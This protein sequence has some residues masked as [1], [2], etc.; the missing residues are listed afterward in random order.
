M[1]DWSDRISKLS[2]K[3][4][5]FLALE[6]QEK[7]EALQRA[8]N[9]P[10]AIVGAGCR[11]PGGADGLDSFWQLLDAG[12]DAVTQVPGDR[13]NADAF[14]DPNPDAGGKTYTKH[15]AFVKNLDLFEPQFFGISP[16]E[17]VSLDPQQR[18]LLEVSWEALEAAGQVPEKLLA[19]RTGVFVGI[20]SGDYMRL[21]T[22]S[23]APLDIYAGTGN[24]PSVA[25]G[26]L[27]YTLGLQGPCVA[28]DT[29][30]SS[31]LIAVHLACQSLRTGECALALAGGV[32]A[33]LTPDT[34][35]M[36][37]RGRMIAPDGHCKT[38]DAAADGY[39]RGEGCGVVVLKRLSDALSA[40]DRILAVL[41]GSAINQDGRSSGL[42]APNGPAQEA[43]IR[44]ALARAAVE[45]A[46]V[47]YVE[48]HGTG[49]P[50]GDPIEVQAL[51]SV[52]GAGRSAADP[53]LIGS[54]KTNIGHLEAAAGVA[55]LIK[56]VLALQHERI[57][58]HINF[59]EP[60]PFIP[61]ASLPVKVTSQAV[62]W[63]RGSRRRIA[64]IS[65]FGFSGSNAHVIVEEAPAAAPA[66]APDVE[67]PQ[68]LLTLSARTQ[69]ALTATAHAYA[70][71]L[72][73]GGAAALAD[74]CFS[75]NTGRS[76]FERRLAVSGPSAEAIASALESFAAGSTPSR[77]VS[78]RVDPGV[79]ADV[80]FLFTGQGSQ[81]RDMA[82]E[83]YDTQ[84]VFRAALDR[85][86]AAL[87]GELPAPLLDVLYPTSSALG[88]SA[89]SA[90]FAS[91]I[92]ETRFTQPALFAVEWA[93]SELWR[94][95][96]VRPAV[97][98][99]HSIGE[100]VAACV[101]GVFS[102][103]DALKL[104]AA[105]GR[106]MQAMPAG[107]AMAAV[108][109]EEARARDA[110]APYASTVSIAAINAPRQVVLS[111]ARTELASAVRQLEQ[112]GVR[113]TWLQVSHAFHS[114]L[115]EP[116]LDEF[117]RVARSVTF[118]APKVDLISNVTGEIAS[119]DELVT[120]GYW[121]RHARA[122][123]QF[124]KSIRTLEA[125]GYGVFLEVGPAATL[126]AL[127]QQSCGE[128]T[129]WAA[130]LKPRAGAWDQMLAALGDLYV[131]GVAIDW[132]GFDRP[133]SR[134]RVDLPT[135]PFQRQRYWI[136]GGVPT[137]PGAARQTISAAGVGEYEVAWEASEPSTPRPVSG[138]A[139][140]FADR[141]GVG[142]SLVQ[143]LTKT[144]A[145]STVVYDA[146]D[147]AAFRDAFEAAR[148]TADGRPLTVVYLWALDAPSLPSG[149]DAAG[150]TGT[151][152][153]VRVL[154]AAV[155]S[156]VA[157]ENMWVVTRGAQAAGDAATP[158]S[159]AQAALWGLVRV[160][161]LEHSNLGLRLIDLEPLPPDDEAAAVF[162]EIS[163][164]D[165]EDQ[166]ALRDGRRLVARLVP[167]E[168]IAA[169]SLQCAPDATYLITGGLGSLGLKI[170]RLLTARGARHLALVGRRAL[171]DRS[172]WASIPDGHPQKA[173]IAAVIE[174]E[175]SGANVQTFSADA[176][177]AARMAEVFEALRQSPWPL[178]GVVHA[179]GVSVTR[180]LI[181]LDQAS[182][183][184]TLGPKINGGWAL[185]EQTR[186][187]PLDFFV[188]FSSIAAVWGSKG[189]AHY[190]AA[191]HFL[192]ALA[193][194]RSSLG[195]TALSINWGPWA[196]GGMATDDT[197][198]A[199]SAMGVQPVDADAALAAFERLVASGRTQATVAA[200]DWDR[201]KEIFNARGRRPL[202]DRMATS[203]RSVEADGG[204]RD[205][206]IAE[207]R[208][209]P[210][211]ARLPLIAGRV[212]HEVATVLGASGLVLEADQRFFDLGMD[213][214]MTVELRR[215]LE[216]R[217]GCPLDTTVAFDY[218]TIERLAQHLFDALEP[219]LGV[220]AAAPKTAPPSVATATAKIAELSDDE[221]ERL[222]AA[223]VLQQKG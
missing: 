55:G 222:F 60:N 27:A 46:D 144:A 184:E 57:P 138:P 157:V 85:C 186:D 140:V 162:A 135:Y 44:D 219:R 154:Q 96:G 200:M 102:P 59:R 119:G 117:E 108:N 189:L 50:L 32:N 191:N 39:G 206:L 123:V 10:I 136:E 216:A 132:A 148:R 169:G 1:N 65:S 214:L 156:G 120:A 89:S 201:F 190:A 98:L 217:F 109:C 91:S 207:L 165:D 87:E 19:T 16:R 166:I 15:G 93:L 196:G 99:G 64:G 13:W 42:T 33:I 181:E 218:P 129:A 155:A 172:G 185:H 103:E 128:G 126:T 125:A 82:R 77:L 168:A 183:L 151:L 110:I 58:A 170:A 160:A 12:A 53:L 175:R 11:F 56:V 182:V 95:W 115:L 101:A 5:A 31:S 18:L 145:V 22:M 197:M 29:A 112:D 158:L 176:G 26:R 159:V 7:V 187:L 124:A 122:A 193:H 149:G 61:W 97:V 146:Q 41:R 208:G 180:S 147:D 220:A 38:F 43:V 141:G 106:L 215:R 167:S 127:A 212:E 14:Y 198:A 37:S 150:R 114:P 209:A 83:L 73:D 130:S 3:R 35:V 28:L 17:A 100:Y 71:R 6:L 70:R 63:R 121:R 49:T 9:E 94:S 164:R 213:S 90:P 111:G 62:D 163:G 199:L 45:P 2:P 177:D 107:G 173:A 202:L 34:N 47:I 81:Y 211:T 51:A 161:A 74:A 223:K 171:P 20:S 21:Q 80:V 179:A 142:A 68:H 48:A 72:A 84:P 203:S 79:S 143:R 75:A 76:H 54:V 134:R 137:A 88:A 113:V 221:V 92:D 153:L 204:G 23:G 30:C 52:L 133:Y 8:Q 104:V 139:I 174:L 24:S 118:C 66:A 69:T 25:A 192:D 152:T 188:T 86:A 40:G 194:H 205:A 67:R 210:A 131:R 78:G 36:L 105:R 4:L 178:R 116:M 195:L